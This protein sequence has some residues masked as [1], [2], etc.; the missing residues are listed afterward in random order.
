MAYVPADLRLQ[1][2]Q[3]WPETCPDRQLPAS[4]EHAASQHLILSPKLREL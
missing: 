3:L 4:Q 1:M 2:R